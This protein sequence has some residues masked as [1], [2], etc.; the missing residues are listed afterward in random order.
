MIMSDDNGQI[1]E[2][3]RQ[4]IMHPIIWAYHIRFC[5]LVQGVFK[6]DAGGI[7]SLRRQEN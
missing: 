5:Y 6:F 2:Y 4:A 1:N 3:G 7:S